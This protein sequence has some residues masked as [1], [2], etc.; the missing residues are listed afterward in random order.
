MYLAKDLAA[1][2]T[3]GGSSMTGCQE[4]KAHVV[5]SYKTRLTEM[6]TAMGRLA[7]FLD[8]RFRGAALG[9][10]TDGTQ[11]KRVYTQVSLCAI[12]LLSACL[13][14]SVASILMFLNLYCAVKRTCLHTL[15]S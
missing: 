1:A 12:T 14:A 8:P 4:F 10:D 9:A 13:H 11:M 5:K 15:D 6:D 2:L 7:L 3:K